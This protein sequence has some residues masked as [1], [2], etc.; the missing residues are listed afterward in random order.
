[1]VTLVRLFSILRPSDV[2]VTLGTT[3]AAAIAVVFSKTAVWRAGVSL[4][5]AGRNPNTS[6]RRRVT[7]PVGGGRHAERTAEARRE[8]PD[9]AQSDGEA[10]VRD[11]PVGVA[12][13]L[14]SALEP[15]SQE[16]PV[17]GL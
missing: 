16:V 5:D 7:C 4:E 17:R 2:V 6:G 12:Q 9:A 10:D 8:R 1:M 15:A 13:Q 3:L 14:S 11:R